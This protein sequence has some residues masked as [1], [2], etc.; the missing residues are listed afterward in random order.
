MFIKNQYIFNIYYYY[1]IYTKQ[2]INIYY[3]YEIAI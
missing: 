2:T 3:N 1:K